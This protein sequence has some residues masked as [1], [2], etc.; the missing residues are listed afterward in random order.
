MIINKTIFDS[1]FDECLD[2]IH[3]SSDKAILNKE[4]KLNKAYKKLVENNDNELQE[5]Y[6]IVHELRTYHLLKTKGLSVTAQN[7]N[8]KGPD[9]YCEE[10]GYI[11]CVS[12]TRG[13]K[14]TE[15]RE[16][17]EKCLARISFTYLAALPR[18]TSVIIDKKKKFEDYLSKKTIDSQVPRIIAINTSVFSNLVSSNSMFELLLQILYGAGNQV[19]WVSK[20]PESCIDEDEGVETHMYNDKGYKHDHLELDLAYFEKEE[21]QNISAIILVKNAITENNIENNFII[22]TNPLAN[23]P[24]NVERLRAFNVMVQRSKDDNMIRYE[25]LKA[26]RLSE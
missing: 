20:N 26:N 15:C 2:I 25:I 21:Y 19:L 12:V 4:E 8:K 17:V 7:D 16:Y 1:I 18:I 9:F 3:S 11:E 14:G 6:S 13:E 22:F 5:F 24:I 10:L 23:V